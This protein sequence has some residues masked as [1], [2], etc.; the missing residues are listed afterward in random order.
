VGVVTAML[1]ALVSVRSI[2]AGADAVVGVVSARSISAGA[3]GTKL[4]AALSLVD[5]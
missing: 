1:L 4:T 2:K 5:T 3:D